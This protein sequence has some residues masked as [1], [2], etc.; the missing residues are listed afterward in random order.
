[1]KKHTSTIRGVHKCLSMHHTFLKGRR[2]NV[3][4]TQ[5]GKKKGDDKKKE[6]KAKNFK[7]HAMR[8][9]GKLAGNYTFDTKYIEVPLDH[10][11]YT[12]NL[13]F[14]LRYLINET[15]YK[16]G[17]PIFFYTG[18]EGDINMFAQNTGFMFDIAPQFEAVVVFVEHRY[19]GESL[20]FGNLSYTSPAYSGYLSS[21][22]AL[23]DFVYVINELQKKYRLP[24]S[25]KKTPVVAFGGSYGG[26]LSAWLK[27]KYPNSVIG[28]IAS[29]AP[30]WIF[31]KQNSCEKCY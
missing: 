5:G 6:I 30:I 1:M 8:R 25:D 10:F 24:E 20:P 4:Y 3:L 17:G 28:A 2:I 12:K 21:T 9:E 15:Y 11:S 13:S 23:A 29:S 14:P 31:S 16:E 22:Q 27:M 26:M 7:L 18:N 19:Y